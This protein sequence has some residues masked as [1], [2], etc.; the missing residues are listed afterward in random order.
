MFKQTWFKTLTIL[1]F[2]LLVVFDAWYFYLLKYAPNKSVLTTFNISTLDTVEGS[3][4]YIVELNYFANKDKS[5]VEL[6]E[7][8]LKYLTNENTSDTMEAGIQ[9]VADKNQSIETVLG[10]YKHKWDTTSVAIATA[11]GGPIGFVVGALNGGSNYYAADF[12][13]CNIY[14]YNRY[15]NISYSATSEINANSA[16]LLPIGEETFLMSFKG[17]QSSEQMTNANGAEVRNCF[18]RYDANYMIMKLFNAIKNSN[19]NNGTHYTKFEFKENMFNYQKSNGNN[20]F[21]D[22]I[23]NE[24]EFSKIQE[25]IMNYFTIKINTHTRGAKIASD[26][27][28]N[29]IENQ[30]NFNLTGNTDINDY[31]GKQQ[32]IKLNEYNF[33]FKLDHDNYY[34]LTLNNATKI[35]LEKYSNCLLL[36]EINL[37]NLII[38]DIQCG[39][40]GFVYDDILTKDKIYQAK[41]TYTNILG[42]TIVQEVDLW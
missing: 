15:A 3:D 19:M 25:K 22:V 16:F 29:I 11:I 35:E 36:I 9:F 10:K 26:S 21:T 14:K 40:N 23:T 24:D 7:F 38:N 12:Q 33:D 4:N 32:L 1:V 20:T 42:E 28:F 30:P 39:V 34:N 17:E 8:K 2:I 13:N 41:L 18:I 5:G 27:M 37:D 31:H 6:L